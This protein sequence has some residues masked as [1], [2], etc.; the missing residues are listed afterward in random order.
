[1]DDQESQRQSS[2]EKKSHSTALKHKIELIRILDKIRKS[3]KKM[4]LIKNQTERDSSV[5][6][7]Q[8]E[9]REELKSM[10]IDI[11]EEDEK[12]AS[13]RHAFILTQIKMFFRVSSYN[14]PQPR[15]WYSQEP[16]KNK[17]AR[18]PATN[19]SDEYN[20]KQSYLQIAKP[21]DNKKRRSVQFQVERNKSEFQ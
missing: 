8:H 2:A 4:N 7:H 12:L 14:L 16:N 11:D 21:V 17:F 6:Q 10:G 1:M 15:P 9:I 13:P 5:R 19:P 3:K 20:R 18:K